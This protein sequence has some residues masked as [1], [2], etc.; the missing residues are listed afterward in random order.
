[1]YTH[2]TRRERSGCIRS[3]VAVAGVMHTPPISEWRPAGG[4]GDTIESPGERRAV[5]GIATVRA[6]ACP[7]VS[8]SAKSRISEPRESAL[9]NHDRC[10]TAVRSERGPGRFRVHLRLGRADVIPHR[11][12]TR[13]RFQVGRGPR[14]FALAR[15]TLDRGHAEDTEGTGHNSASSSTPSGPAVI[16]ERLL[17]I[18]RM[19]TTFACAPASSRASSPA[20]QCAKRRRS[21]S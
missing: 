6:W 9:G 20:Y 18:Q 17:V 10:A 3:V 14:L 21:S 16:F 11:I 12:G 8:V 7:R 19:L 15:A 13:L 1:M 4:A 5:P 2:G